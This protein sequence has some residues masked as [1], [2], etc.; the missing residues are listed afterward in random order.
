MRYLTI[1][2]FVFLTYGTVYA[3]TVNNPI[4]V[5]VD[6]E[7]FTCV[8]DETWFEV[9][10]LY[11]PDTCG[12]GISFPDPGKYSV[13]FYSGDCSDRVAGCS[14]TND[15]G[16]VEWE[17][18]FYVYTDAGNYNST[19]GGDNG[20]WGSVTTAESIENVASGVVATGAELWPMLAMAGIAIA[21]LLGLAFINFIN[22]SVETPT[23]KKTAKKE[24][25]IYHSAE[26]L[27]FKRNYGNK[28]P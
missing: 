12:S 17:R 27:E 26:D 4:V 2:A 11:T 21:F 24:D 3:G 10:G 13:I 25:F 9:P 20:M 22:Q 28:E 1:I 8:G 23:P 14:G 18:T 5:G 7:H 15:T 19:W 16:S 6:A